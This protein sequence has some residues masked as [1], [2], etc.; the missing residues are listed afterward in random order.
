[1]LRGN[2]AQ[3]IFFRDEDH[4]HFASLVAEGVARFSH[5]IH[6]YCWMDNHVH[7][8]VQ[9]AEVP[10]SRIMQNVAFRYTRWI[11]QRKSGDTMLIFRVFSRICG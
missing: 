4:E 6:A 10:L 5:R 3:Q 1:M 7:L 8:A 11:N 9:V 2:G